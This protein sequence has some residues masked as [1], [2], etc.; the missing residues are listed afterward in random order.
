MKKIGLPLIG[1]VFAFFV[2]FA[3][4]FGESHGGSKR[5]LKDFSTE[6]EYSTQSAVIA[7]YRLPYPG[8]LPDSPFYIIKM[9]RD[10]FR[11][12]VT[13]DLDD[14]ASLFILYGDKR[15]GASYYLA[16]GNKMPLAYTTALKA[17]SYMDQAVTVF[18]SKNLSESSKNQLGETLDKSI[19][20]HIETIEEI[21]HMVEGDARVKF[22]RV[23]ESYKLLG[24]K[25]SN[26]V[27]R[28]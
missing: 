4:L 8:V 15:V 18:E 2:L 17:L 5:V 12:W 13:R 16:S 11:L 6:V 20:L 27:S 1:V 7:V 3:S 14:R 25:I 26:A 10:R 21:V 19:R 23:L 24:V 22:E 28:D 9:V